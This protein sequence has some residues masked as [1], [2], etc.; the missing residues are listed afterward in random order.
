MKIVLLIFCISF[1]TTAFTQARLVLNNDAFV[2]IDNAAFVVL[3]NPATNA[4]TQLGTGGRIVS[5]AEFDR[6]KW[7]IGTNTGLFTMPWSTTA[8]V[9]F[10]LSVNIAIAGAGAGNLTFSTYRGLS[11]DNNTY[12]PSDVTHMLDY[13]TGT[14]NNSNNVIDRFWIVDPIGYGTKPSA[15]IDLTYIDAE[16]MPAGNTITESDLGAQRFNTGAGIWGDYLPSG[17]VNTIS[18]IVSGI[19]ANPANFFRSWTLSEVSNP[20]PVELLNYNLACENGSVK[21]EWSTASET[22]IQKFVISGS[23]DGITYTNLKDVSPA[24]TVGVTNYREVVSNL[25]TYFALSTV[26]LGGLTNVHSI[27]MIDCGT[28]ASTVNAFITNG[29]ISANV[30]LENADKVQFSIYDA[31]GKLI[32]AQNMMLNENGSVVDLEKLSLSNGI[33]FLKVLSIKNKLVETIKL[34]YY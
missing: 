5:E 17:T 1:T 8:G 11:W 21:V 27:K 30:L 2:V 12:R 19:P 26:E 15:T 34:Y 31:T 4:I 6:L 10:P 7:N 3:D 20:L 18:N 22:D 23:N 16:W 14:V 25:Y 28:E 29:N 9:E 32:K 33:Y 13:A 24:G